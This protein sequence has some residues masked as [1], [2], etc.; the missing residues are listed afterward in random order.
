MAN[1]VIYCDLLLQQG[2]GLP[3]WKPDPNANLPEAYTKQGISIGDLGLLT[4]DGGFDFLFNVHADA[5]DP[6]NQFLGTPASFIPLPLDPIRDVIKTTFQHPMKAYI[7]RNI[8]IVL[9]CTLGAGAQVVYVVSRSSSSPCLS[10][11]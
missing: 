2:H 3:L 8:E 6:V 9:G 10:F 4:D 1:S 7:M 5:H 11:A